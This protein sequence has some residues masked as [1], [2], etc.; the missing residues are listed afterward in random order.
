MTPGARLGQ[1]DPVALAVVQRAELRLEATG[2][3]VDE[4]QQV[5]VDVT[6]EE[7]HRFGAPRQ[8]HLTVGVGEHQ[9]GGAVRV[10]GVGGLQFTGQHVEWSQ[11]SDGAVRGRIVAAVQIGGASGEAAAAEFVV[12][13]TV[14][15]GVQAPGC[16]PLAQVNERFH[17]PPRR[18]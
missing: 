8:Q 5:A 18:K 14:E 15:V 1:V 16:L 2:A 13:E 12:L 7:R 10:G 4:S 6:D 3:L 9:Q 17:D 11:R